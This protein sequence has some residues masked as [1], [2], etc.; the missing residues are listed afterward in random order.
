[1]RKRVAKY[2]SQRKLGI[3][4][5]LFFMNLTVPVALAQS[6][7]SIPIMRVHTGMTNVSYGI[8]S[9]DKI[10]FDGDILSILRTEE[11]KG[12]TFNME[13]ISCITF[14]EGEISAIESPEE[15]QGVWVRYNSA[16]KTIE[17]GG[18]S[19]SASVAVY[20]M[21]GCAVWQSAR[22]SLPVSVP[23]ESPSAGIYIVKVAD[24]QNI[25]TYKII[26]Y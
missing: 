6:E 12:I 19:P 9:I 10:L 21:Q 4:L 24:K 8:D 22:I 2:Y 3:M 14:G 16:S 13:E 25:G 26:K 5:M 15:N 20:N 1:M 11:P 7:Q 23:F 17:V 18:S